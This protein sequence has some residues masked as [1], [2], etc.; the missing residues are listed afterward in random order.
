MCVFKCVCASVWATDKEKERWGSGRSF[1]RGKKGSE[2]KG[3]I[4]QEQILI[5][6]CSS[7]TCPSLSLALSSPLTSFVSLPP[8]PVSASLPLLLHVSLICFPSKSS[9]YFIPFP[10]NAVYVCVCVCVSVFAVSLSFFFL[11]LS[12]VQQLLEGSFSLPL[13]HSSTHT[14]TDILCTSFNL[15]P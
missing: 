10:V 7:P 12:D 9:S 1:F 4:C 13:K 2:K 15:F 5:L 14:H 8:F 6:S 11:S 3:G